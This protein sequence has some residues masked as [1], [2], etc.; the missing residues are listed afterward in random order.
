MSGSDWK[1]FMPLI[2]KIGFFKN[3]FYKKCQLPLLS[4]LMIK[5]NDFTFQMNNS[6]IQN[7]IAT[8]FFIPFLAKTLN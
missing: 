4:L 6:D 1:A 7:N 8:T 3:I 2:L 5:M